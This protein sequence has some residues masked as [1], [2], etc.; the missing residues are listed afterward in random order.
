MKKRILFSLVLTILLIALSGTALAAGYVQAT[1][2]DVYLRTSPSLNGEKL[3]A[4]QENQTAAYLNGS[5][6]DER[7]VLWYR[8]RFEGQTGWISSRYTTLY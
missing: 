6:I 3:D 7:G 2:G 1:G 4:M 8:V 5:A